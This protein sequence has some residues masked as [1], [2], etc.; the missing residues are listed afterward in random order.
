MFKQDFPHKD[1]IERSKVN[2]EVFPNKNRGTIHKKEIVNTLETQSQ[3][4]EDKIIIDN[5]NNTS[6][7]FRSK[8][9]SN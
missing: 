5:N 9:D 1:E 2:L 8:L 4:S 3:G 6:E 7:M